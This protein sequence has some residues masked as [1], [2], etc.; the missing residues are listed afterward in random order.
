MFKAFLS[1]LL[2][3]LMLLPAAAADDT[4]TVAIL[5]FGDSPSIERASGA[6]L[7]VL[8]SYGY[9]SAEENNTLEEGSDFQGERINIIWGDAGYDIP[10]VSIMVDSALDQEPDVLVTLSTSVTLVAVNATLDMDEPL[11]V[12]FTAVHNPFEAGIAEAACIKPANVT[13]TEIVTSMI[14][15]LTPCKSRTP[16]SPPSAPYSIPP[17]RAASMALIPS[18]KSL[19]SAASLLMRRA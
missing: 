11:P 3:L 8:Q 4:P 7:D 13:G 14:M 6:I 10:T 15:S 18:P 19:P 5:Y 9:L 2:A 1:L 12:L 17:W 16:I